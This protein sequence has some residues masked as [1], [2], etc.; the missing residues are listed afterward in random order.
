MEFKESRTAEMF[1]AA[2]ARGDRTTITVQMIVMQIALIAVLPVSL[3]DKERLVDGMKLIIDGLSPGFMEKHMG[4]ALRTA[5]VMDADK[6]D[7]FAG[8]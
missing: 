3:K 6:R 8:R 5:A 4:D 7:H 1:E 2:V